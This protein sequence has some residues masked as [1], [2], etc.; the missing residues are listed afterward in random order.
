M[1]LN[2]ISDIIHISDEVSPCALQPDR[3]VASTAVP[4]QMQISYSGSF[5]LVSRLHSQNIRFYLW[6]QGISSKRMGRANI[7]IDE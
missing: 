7:I 6:T 3:H 2:Q 4:L 5:P 1:M